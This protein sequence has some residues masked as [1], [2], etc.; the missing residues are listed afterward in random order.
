MGKR[1]RGGGRGGEEGGEGLSF[2]NTS[3]GLNPTRQT[4]D[5]GNIRHI[6]PRGIGKPDGKVA[7]G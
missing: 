4:W 5:W 3:Q 1:G 7:K 2:R 6:P